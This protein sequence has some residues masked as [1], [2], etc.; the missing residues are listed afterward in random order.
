[1]VQFFLLRKTSEVSRKTTRLQRSKI[2]STVK[3]VMF[4]SP[5]ILEVKQLYV[6]VLFA[7]MSV[8]CLLTQIIKSDYV[9]LII[10]CRFPSGKHIAHMKGSSIN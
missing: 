2:Y 10:D 1:M 3:G 4:A 9:K 7:Q 5:S 6:Y 8:F